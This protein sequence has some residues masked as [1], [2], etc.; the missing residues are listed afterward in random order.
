MMKWVNGDPLGGYARVFFV[1][2][3]G[4]LYQYN[5]VMVGIDPVDEEVGL[6]II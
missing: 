2:E 3:V 4:F 5:V 6:A 1:V